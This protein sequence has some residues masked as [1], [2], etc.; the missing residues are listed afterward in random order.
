ML[1]V[2]NLDGGFCF[3]GRVCI[4]SGRPQRDELTEPNFGE[5]AGKRE[6]KS[7]LYVIS[8]RSRYM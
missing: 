1:L 7:V 2:I 5:G 8:K 4:G 6:E 3:T